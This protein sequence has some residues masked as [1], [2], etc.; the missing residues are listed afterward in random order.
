MLRESVLIKVL[1][2]KQKSTLVMPENFKE[3]WYRGR[4]LLV[5]PKVEDIEVD[6]IVIFPPSFRGVWPTIID[7]N[8]EEAIIL[9]E[10][11]IWAIE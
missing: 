7:D 10:K 6:D 11:D 1:P 8:N 9:P 4:V 2:K 5:G 3:D